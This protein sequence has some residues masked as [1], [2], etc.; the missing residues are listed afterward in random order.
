MTKRLNVLATLL[1]GLLLSVSSAHASGFALQEQSASGLG[2][3]FAGGAAS[4]EDNSAIWS[5]PAALTLLESAEVQVG[6]HWVSVDA[7][8]ANTGTTTAGYPTQGADGST[9]ESALV[10]NLYYSQPVS[11]NLVLGLGV[12]AAF[13]LTTDWGKDWFGRYIADYSDL[14]DVNIQPTIAYKVNE[15]LSIGF[16]VDYANVEAEL[17]NAV[18]MGLVFLNAIQTGQIP[19]AAVPAAL[20]GDVRSN[21]IGTKYDGHAS[22]KG[23]GA[24]WGY[25]A[26]LLYQPNADTRI[27]LH[28]RSSIEVDLDGD[29]TFDVGALSSILGSVFPAQ[30]GKVKLELPSIT[31]LSVFHQIND[32]WSIMGDVQYTTWSSF[33]TLTIDFEQATPPT[34]VVPENWEDVWRFSGGVSYQA[35]EDLK[36]RVGMAFDQSPI[37]SP[38]YRSPRIPDSDRVWF[39]AG[40]EYVFNDSFRVNAGATYIM[41]EDATIDN[42]THSAGFAMKAD[43]EA[44]VTIISLSGIVSF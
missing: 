41:V 27:G 36:L 8:L 23:D 10:P 28:Y 39:S 44:S 16:G 42:D 11:D 33:E 14:K 30:G 4:A 37:P 15:K 25:N 20:I 43:M 17:T 34:S 26:G 5:N 9:S 22:I 29:V 31:N 3:A 24:A 19:A 32:A 1:C 13:G 40:L 6:A 38:A 21:L 18:N 7:D 2:N 12:T 35:T